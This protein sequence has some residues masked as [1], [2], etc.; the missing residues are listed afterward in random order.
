[1]EGRL[2]WPGAKTS[3]WSVTP[4]V[5]PQAV[6]D[7]CNGQ[8]GVVLPLVPPELSDLPESTGSPKPMPFE[9]V[10]AP[11]P[12]G[13][14]KHWGSPQ[15][16][17]SPAL[18]SSP[19]PFLSHACAPVLGQ[20]TL[21]VGP[22]CA[23]SRDFRQGRFRLRSW[24]HTAAILLAS[25]WRYSRHTVRPACPRDT[26]WHLWQERAALVNLTLFRPYAL[27]SSC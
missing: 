13:L 18:T 19:G 6:A 11:Q 24:R 2:F 26:A 15:R 22:T 3:L 10:G 21:V 27:R 17:A 4:D 23:R 14:Q 16:S 12:T 20:A 5:P 8:R 25:A 7:V 1:M 9:S